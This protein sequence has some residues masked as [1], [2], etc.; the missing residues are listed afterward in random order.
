MKVCFFG[1]YEQGTYNLLLKKILEL[2]G[3]EV[4]ECHENVYGVFS[5]FCAY[6]KLPFKHRNLHYDVMIIPWRGIM[7]LPLAKI[8]SNRPIIQFAFISIY[9]TLVNDRKIVNPNSIKA[10]IIH[11]LEK[12][13][14]KIP[15]MI[16]LDS[17]QEINYFVN[18]YS[19]SKKKFRRLFLSADETKFRPIE[20][21]KSNKHF[22][23]L[24][25]GSFIPVHGV[26][27]ILE[28]AKVLSNHDDI[29]FKFCGDGQIRSKMQNLAKKY[30]LKN[31]EF[32]GY[33]SDETL[34]KNIANSDVCLGLL[35]QTK[36][37]IRC[38]SN[39]T[40]EILASKRPLIALDSVGVKEI[41]VENGSN[42]ILVPQGNPN[43]LARAI[44]FLKNNSDI[45]E[46]IAAE[47]YLLFRRNLSM[48]KMGKKAL[49]YIKEL[50]PNEQSYYAL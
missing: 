14:Y 23:V 33:V 44:L 37:A 46:R 8:I 30:E 28:A 3:I 39:K 50:L 27:V 22:T 2:Q 18:E 6:L 32:L 25:F 29:I 41:G 4:I 13:F 47:G 40:F 11:F 5:F 21:K 45:K 24:Y 48:E 26:E 17:F 10:K 34:L 20:F 15:D 49:G 19:L 35:G 1:S 31:V 16:I 12:Q 42:C 7:T 43:E 38:I 9:D 36:K